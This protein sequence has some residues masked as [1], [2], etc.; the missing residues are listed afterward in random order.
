[1]RYNGFKQTGKGESA[2][3]ERTELIRCLDWEDTEKKRYAHFEQLPVDTNLQLIQ[4]GYHQTDANYSYGPMIRDHYLIHFIRRGS[5]MMTD[6]QNE[7]SIHENQCFLISPG[8]MALHRA[9]QD[10][11]WEYYWLGFSGP[12]GESVLSEMQLDA[13]HP[14]ADLRNS[15][16]L[17]ALLDR[18]VGTI[19]LHSG[20]LTLTGLLFELMDVLRDSRGSS[21]GA[22]SAATRCNLQEKNVQLVENIKIMVENSFGEK[23]NIS[24]IARNLGYSRS[25]MTE[26]FHRETGLSISQYITESRLQRAELMMRDP[27][28]SVQQIAYL[29]GY[30]DPLF[31]SR[32]FKKRFGVG[33]RSFRESW[34]QGGIASEDR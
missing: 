20:Y 24:E 28:H 5:G 33:P 27:S 25:Y 7:Y 9:T 8:R 13:A 14:I 15:D 3:M 1:M 34:K 31:F 30:S 2:M 4:V 16:A 19:Q 11:P 26:V 17:F 22:R 18:M 29:C 12:W 32:M 10:S 23:L 6:M 21:E